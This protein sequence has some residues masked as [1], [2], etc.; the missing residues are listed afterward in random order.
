[1]VELCVRVGRSRQRHAALHASQVS[2]GA[3]RGRR[4]Q[5]QGECEHLRWLVPPVAAT[6]G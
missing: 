2:P 4:L 5:L 3:V 1:M 6:P